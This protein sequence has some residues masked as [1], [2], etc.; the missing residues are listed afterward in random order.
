MTTSMTTS[1]RRYAQAA[2]LAVATVLFLLLGIGALGIVGDGDRDMLYLAAPVVAL[3][4]AAAA[5]FRPHGMAAA[6]A[7]AAVTTLVA[8]VVAVVLV[9]RA[10]ETASLLDIAGLSSMYALLFGASAW[11]FR[12]SDRLA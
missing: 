7:A 9:V 12:R 4:G 6:M 1:R 2:A 10:D 8:G 3:V 11:L 5:R